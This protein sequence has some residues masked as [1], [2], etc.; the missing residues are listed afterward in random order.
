MS[1]NLTS[2][3]SPPLGGGLGVGRGPSPSCV[4]V[5]VRPVD[6]A[7]VDDLEV[8]DAEVEVRAFPGVVRA[9]LGATVWARPGV[10]VDVVDGAVVFLAKGASLE[11]CRPGALER[12]EVSVIL[13][14]PDE[15]T[16]VEAFD[17]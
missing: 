10:V 12:G 5:D 6:A 2:P 13:W 17:V 9:G 11:E 3:A 1:V 7:G 4:V 8:E 15:A 16:G 14:R